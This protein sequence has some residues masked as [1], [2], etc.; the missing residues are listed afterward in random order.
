MSQHVTAD[1]SEIAIEFEF[2]GAYLRRQG[3]PSMDW[4]VKKVSSNYKETIEGGGA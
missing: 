3:A 2:I 4:M 1:C